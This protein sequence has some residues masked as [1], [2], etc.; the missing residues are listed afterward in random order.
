MTSTTTN[1]SSS[2]RLAFWSF[3]FSLL[4]HVIRAWSSDIWAYLIQARNGAAQEPHYQLAPSSSVITSNFIDTSHFSH[5]WFCHWLLSCL[6]TMSFLVEQIIHA[7]R[8]VRWVRYNSFKCWSL[9]IDDW[10]Q[11]VLFFICVMQNYRA[12]QKKSSPC[13]SF[14]KTHIIIGRW[15][16]CTKRL[17]TFGNYFG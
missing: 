17:A 2:Y 4:P 13:V 5:S 1:I 12:K 7:Q 14:L 11:S 8:C 3:I 9:K 10:G 15:V 16:N 6:Q